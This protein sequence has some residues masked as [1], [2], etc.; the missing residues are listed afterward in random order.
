MMERFFRSLKKECVS[1][2]LF[3]NFAAV[4]REIAAW[5]RSYNEAH[6]HQALG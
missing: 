2:H 6:P 4:R 5:I 1:Q 3:P